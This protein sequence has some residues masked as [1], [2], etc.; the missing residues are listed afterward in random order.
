[1]EVFNIGIMELLFI[2]ILAL[3]LFGPAGL[4]DNMRKAGRYIY[5][6]L[7][8]PYWRT[9]LDVQQEIREMPTRLIREA[10]LEESLDQFNLNTRDVDQRTPLAG[11]GTLPSDEV[12]LLPQTNGSTSNLNPEKKEETSS[13]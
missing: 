6:F 11:A 13:D 3:V 12:P 10:G 2:A 8:S 5:K 1:M 4:I 7:R 9:F